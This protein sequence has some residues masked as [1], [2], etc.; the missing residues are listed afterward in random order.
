MRR[1]RWVPWRHD[2]KTYARTAAAVGA[3]L[4]VLLMSPGA[5]GT[6]D[7]TGAA[8]ADEPITLDRDGQI[9]DKVGALGD[10][11]GDVARALRQLDTDHRVQLFVAYVRD[12]SGIDGQDWANTTANRNG[13]G[14]SDVLFAVATHDRQYAVSAD[15]D[16]GITQRRSREV[17]SD[18]VEPALRE[19]DWAGAAI[20]AAHGYD[21]LL[22]GRPVSSPALTPGTPDPGGVPDPTG[23]ALWVPVAAVGGVG[24]AAVYLYKRRWRGRGT[25]VGAD[26]DEN[27]WAPDRSRRPLPEL[28]A[29]SRQLLVE[30]DD[31]IR[32]SAE[33]LGFASAQFGDETAR[34]FAAALV[35]ART[36]LTEA[37]RLRQQLDDA[38]PGNDA[39]KRT[40][41]AEIITRCENANHRLDAEAGSFDQLRALEAN[42]GQVLDQAEA[43][44]R[45]LAPR[46]AAAESALAPLARRYA[47]NALAP[48][49]GHPA[50]ARDRLAFAQS[51]L[52]E[53]RQA[54]DAED[55]SRVAVSV[56][57]A[58]SAL[59]QTA[60]FVDAINRRAE[61]LAEAAAAIPDAL[62]ETGTDLADARGL[63]EGT[64]RGVAG[65]DLR[66]RVARAEAVAADVR[67][68]AAAGHCDPLSALR[69]IEAAHST[70]NE[71]L[72]GAREPEVREQRARGLLDQV[73]LAARS[74]V[75]AAQDFIT[76]NR[77]GIGS[78]ARTRLAEAE[79][80]L[81]QAA[82]LTRTDAAG[83]LRQAQRADAAAQQAGQLAEEDVSGYGGPSGRGVAGKGRGRGGLGGGGGMGGAVLGGMLGGGG[84]QGGF[85]GGGPGGGGSPGSFG[86]GGTRGRMGRGGRS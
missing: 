57:T 51:A 41:T 61:E 70:L 13:L 82:A 79:R 29:E 7:G 9:T 72:A 50:R 30:T 6:T 28:D 43:T 78:R 24:V 36:E 5:L 52:A 46:V 45:A 66:G 26:E 76:T 22:S 4:A 12:F 31:A 27:G 3:A 73:L 80:C 69:R 33:E 71:A 75:G 18:A 15:Q 42:P 62:T 23:A 84:R 48:V 35:Y 81:T 59:D 8:Q 17:N 67:Q 11:R 55:N 32:T 65:T 47:D 2:R 56:R 34:P 83:A 64:A 44:A 60:T 74:E 21:A 39:A 58:E 14:Q 10:R 19:N 25:A 20:G 37:F 16:S 53:A 38:F 49:T 40:M 54:L 85:R 1:M 86:G 63:L 77:G 68:E